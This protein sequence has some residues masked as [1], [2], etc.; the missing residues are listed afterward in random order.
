[1]QSYAYSF[2]LNRPLL[3]KI[4]EIIVKY[5]ADIMC[6]CV[7]TVCVRCTYIVHAVLRIQSF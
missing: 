5:G 3:P 6:V 1:M 7:F 4:E 2:F